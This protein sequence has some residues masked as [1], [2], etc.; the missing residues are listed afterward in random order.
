MAT[1]VENHSLPTL[2]SSAPDRNCSFRDAKRTR[3]FPL[4][5]KSVVCQGTFLREALESRLEKLLNTCRGSS[6]FY[7][8]NYCERTHRTMNDWHES[9]HGTV[10]GWKGLPSCI[11]HV[12]IPGK[13]SLILDLHLANFNMRRKNTRQQRVYNQISCVS[14]QAE[15]GAFPVAV[16]RCYYVP[17]PR[18]I[19]TG[20]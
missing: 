7:F 8:H 16:P 19:P 2:I 9:D 10:T 13:R 3:E 20:W 15:R 18:L 1:L 11:L 5:R 14:F 4:H 17:E 6:C 12:G